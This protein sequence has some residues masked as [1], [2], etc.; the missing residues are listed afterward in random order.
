MTL[1]PRLVRRGLLTEFQPSVLAELLL[2]VLPPLPPSVKSTN[3]SSITLAVTT[4]P[5]P[6]LSLPSAA[7]VWFCES[8]STLLA[9]FPSTSGG[10][11]E[12][13]V[14]TGDVRLSSPDL[15]LSLLKS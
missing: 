8:F 5:T 12:V 14:F 13:A 4:S 3:T 15:A 11:G 10:T 9:P 1:S 2:S 6:P 7:M